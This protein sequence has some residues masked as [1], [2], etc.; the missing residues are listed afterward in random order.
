MKVKAMTVT[1]ASVL[2]VT[3]TSGFAGARAARPANDDFAAATV[4]TDAEFAENGNLKGA[5]LEP[6]ETQPSCGTL[7]ASVWYRFEAPAAKRFAVGI[8]TE[9]K[10]GLAAY[11]ATEAGLE[12]ISCLATGFGGGVEFTAEVGDVVWIQVGNAGWTQGAFELKLKPSNWQERKLHEF[13]Y[14][15]KIQ[16][17]RIPLLSV[18]GVP[19]ASDPSMYDIEIGISEQQ[20][21]KRGILTFGLVKERVDA[22]LITIPASTTSVLVTIAARYDESQYACMVDEGEGQEC[23]AYT[24]ISDPGHVTSREGANAGLVIHLSAVRNGEV[25]VEQSVVVPFVGQIAGL[26]P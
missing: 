3:L 26:I 20:P 15:R 10:A 7:K 23:S 21:I 25:L 18:H 17:Q 16:E 14:T 22:E 9:F 5:T 6:G 12:E 2:L 4:I 11:H 1:I 19:R 13:S 8:R 24:P